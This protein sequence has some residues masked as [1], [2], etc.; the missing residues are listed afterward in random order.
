M[1]I[2][3]ELYNFNPDIVLAIGGGTVIDL[4]KIACITDL[5]LIKNFKKK[6]NRL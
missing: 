3:K 2:I 4:A 6:N 1:V 5:S